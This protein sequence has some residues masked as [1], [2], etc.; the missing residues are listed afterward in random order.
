MDNP[1]V[2]DFVHSSQC[3][4][5]QIAWFRR[6]PIHAT[7]HAIAFINRA[8]DNHAIDRLQGQTIFGANFSAP[9]ALPFMRRAKRLLIE[10]IELTYPHRDIVR[11][12]MQISLRERL[13][14][15]CS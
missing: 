5:A 4:D 15:R 2:S 13:I 3:G 1:L 14:A 11:A 10:Y 6:H 8:I 9:N 7:L 12:M